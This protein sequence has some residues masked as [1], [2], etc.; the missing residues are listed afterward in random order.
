MSD[1][2]TESRTFHRLSFCDA[3]GALS[4]SGRPI[5]PL[6]DLLISSC[7]LTLI[8][9]RDQATHDEVLLWIWCSSQQIV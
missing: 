7:G 1:N 6:V 9:P 8:N 5:V 3:I 4:P 2:A